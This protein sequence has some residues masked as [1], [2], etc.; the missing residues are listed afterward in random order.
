M[1]RLLVVVVLVMLVLAGAMGL[2][3]I[4]TA[5]GK[6]AVM[7]ANGGAPLPPPPKRSGRVEAPTVLVP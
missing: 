1:Y 7:M 5:H 6:G 4:V 3:N 2:K